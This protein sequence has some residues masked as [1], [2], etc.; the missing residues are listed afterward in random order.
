MDTI[1]IRFGAGGPPAGRPAG[2]M[3]ASTVPHVAHAADG[4]HA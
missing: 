1:A 2:R 4:R 3:T